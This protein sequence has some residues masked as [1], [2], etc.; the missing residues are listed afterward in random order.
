MTSIVLLALSLSLSA[1]ARYDDHA[2]VRVWV[3]DHAELSWLRSVSEELLQE[4]PGPGFVDARVTDAQRRALA[5]AGV[6]YEL[7][8]EDLQH[9]IDAERARLAA[10]RTPVAGAWFDDFRDYDSIMA[11]LDRIAADAP[12]L[13]R[14]V[15]LGSSLEG[16]PIRALRL[17]HAPEGAKAVLF[18]GT[19]HAREW[20]AT[21][22]SMCVAD[23]F[24]TGDGVDDDVTDLLASVEVWVVPVLNPDGYVISWTDDRYWRKNARDG[25]GVD[26]NRN[27]D[28]Q[29]AVVGAS[30]NPY[31]EDYHGP[32]A[33]SEPET[34]ALRDFI[35]A[36]PQIVAHIDFH[37]Y[38]QLVLR[39][40]GYTYAAPSDEATL[41]QLGEQMSDAM[42]G[43]TSTDYA[44]IH[45]AELYPAAGA[46]D[47][48]SY[49]DRGIM[50]FTIELRGDD[51]VVPPSQIAPACA[52]SVA[53]ARALAT[54]VRE[55]VPP[56]PGGQADGSDGADGHEGD[57]TAS[58][59][60]TGAGTTDDTAIDDTA[61]Q[62]DDAHDGGVADPDDGALPP[63]FG[64]DGAR[65]GGC[66]CVSATPLVAGD[67][68]PLLV[69][70]AFARRRRYGT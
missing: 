14:V 32:F 15:E 42:W 23:A 40:W 13:A 63:G 41:A 57:P 18:T 65:T 17:S 27:W 10:T 21:M 8:R 2:I 9:D 12:T 54:W 11:E 28:Y 24:A 47:D 36:R 67:A 33:F 64:Q 31:D 1:P 43:A 26:L 61:G 38:S 70:T 29:W 3:D 50:A 25:Y 16:R 59:E 69:L 66:A 51:F 49:G 58:D 52:E 62:D 34:V 55:Q 56:D 48:W 19:M 6:S 35:V 37:S 68:A 20:L 45:A 7:R 5:A 53:A 46:V 39:P 44:S 30:D 60:G 22:V 4:R